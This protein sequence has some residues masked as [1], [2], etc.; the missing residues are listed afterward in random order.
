MRTQSGG[1]R[2][3]PHMHAPRYHLF[4][5]Y[6]SDYGNRLPSRF[7]R[8]GATGRVTD[9]LQCKFVRQSSR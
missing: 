8:G 7:L 4:E 1:G 2:I 3:T 9:F 5:K 6:A